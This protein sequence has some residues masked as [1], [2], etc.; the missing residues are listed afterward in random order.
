[1]EKAR[2][3]YNSDIVEKNNVARERGA[4]AAREFSRVVETFNKVLEY[5]EKIGMSLEEEL[6][7]CGRQVKSNRENLQ[8]LE[9]NVEIYNQNLEKITNNLENLQNQETKIKQDYDTFLRGLGTRGIAENSDSESSQE[10][11]ASSAKPSR[12]SLMERR[13]GYLQKL[14]ENFT[15]M[16]K[17]LLDIEKLMRELVQARSEIS[18]KKEEAIKH[19]EI[20]DDNESKLRAEV[21]RIERELET[22]LQEEEILLNEFFKLISNVEN[23]V[24]LSEETDRVLFTS[25]TASGSGYL[26]RENNEQGQETK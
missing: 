4:A 12:E 11:E 10:N 8:V 20:L 9:H 25:L 19:K 23:S 24:D 1:M 7:G 17:E 3:R 22:S 15:K 6:A 21:G 26:P 5:K 14:D 18:L 13:Q 16:E 2:F